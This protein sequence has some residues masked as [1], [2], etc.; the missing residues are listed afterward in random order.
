MKEIRQPNLR[1]SNPSFSILPPYM[2]EP[3]SAYSVQARVAVAL[4][5]FVLAADARPEGKAADPWA[6]AQGHWAFRPPQKRAVPP[7]AHPVDFFIRARQRELGL[8]ATPTP[9]A[10]RSTLLRRVT[11]DLTGL[12]PSLEELENFRGDTNADAYEKVVSRLLASPR[13]G[14]RWGRMWLDL[15]RWAESDGY[16]AN[17]IRAHAWRYRDYVVQSFNNDKPYHRFLTE[18]LAGDELD[19]LTDDNLVATGFLAAGRVNNNEEDKAVQLNESIVDIA[20]AAAAVTLGLTL[21]CAQCHDH[22]FEPLTIS[23]Y[24]AWHGLFL[25][26]QVNSLLLKDP[27]LVGAWERSRPP[28]LDTAQKLLGELTGPVRAKL[29]EEV[30]VQLS[31]AQRTALELSPA[32]RTPEQIELAKQAEKAMAVSDEAVG[33]ALS[34]DDQKLMTELKKKMATLEKRLSETR[35]QTWGYYSP[36]TSPHVIETLPP[37][38]MY[39][40][41][42]KPAALK[43]ATPTVL[44][45]GSVALRGEAVEPGVPSVLGGAKL[46]TR[47][48]LTQ[49]LASAD[50]PLTARVWA[51]YVWQQHFGR[52][53]VETPDNFGVKGER[54]F[55]Q[56]LLDWLACELREQGWS[57][58]HLHRLI[59]TSATYRQGSQFNAENAKHDPENRYAWRWVPR[60]LESEAIRD[61]LLAVAGTLDLRAGGPSDGPD[62][63][64]QRRSL[65]QMQRRLKLPAEQSLFDAGTA[66]ES[67]PRRHC[68]TVP[69]QPLYLLNNESCVKLAKTFAARVR[70]LAGEDRAGQMETAFRLALGREPDESERAAAEAFFSHHGASE[71]AET[72]HDLLVDFCQA[73]VNLNEFVYIP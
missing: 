62:Q 64:S 43:E 6:A 36:V 30:R 35:P 48:E 23:D 11:L 27:T 60:R 24:Y 7:D 20:N 52:G 67:C 68:S 71:N 49:W 1:D 5:L 39:P 54:P 28:E 3:R 31:V 19:P 13:Y 72:P 32:H 42:Y 2:V 47:R 58:K 56:A 26:G 70:A 61:S 66:N 18:Q 45:R 16:E 14:E 55:N 38:G 73:I 10:E 65:Y 63:P 46:K 22:K 57:T 15:A 40:F 37:R 17:E 69:L 8:S 12:P 51:N 53:L 34:D 21:N 41:P 44:K 4:A 25:R 59:V 29:R 50:N 33:K 9:A